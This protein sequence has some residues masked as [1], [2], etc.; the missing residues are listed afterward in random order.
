MVSKSL[1]SHESVNTATNIYLGDFIS[2]IILAS[3]KMFQ[4][5]R[6]MSRRLTEIVYQGSGALKTES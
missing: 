5:Y 2:A 3:V 6:Y 4:S 1:L